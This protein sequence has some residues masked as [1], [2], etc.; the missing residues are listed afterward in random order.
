M[1]YWLK[2]KAVT[3]IADEPTTNINQNIQHELYGLSARKPIC[4]RMQTIAG[5]TITKS[6]NLTKSNIMS[7]PIRLERC[8]V[9][10]RA[11][12]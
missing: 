6:I 3:K 4:C 10:S 7:P 2:N 11:I 12:D 1:P 9:G 8:N 5:L